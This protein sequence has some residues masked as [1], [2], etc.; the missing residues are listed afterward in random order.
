MS[1]EQALMPED[2]KDIIYRLTY[3]LLGKVAHYIP[4]SVSPNQITIVAFVSAMIACALLYFISSPM[5]YLYWAIFNFI[6]YVLDALDGI[7]ARLTRQ[8]SEYGAFLD[9]VL[10]NIFFLI[11]FTVFT[12]KFDLSHPLYVLALMTRITAAVMVFIV[13]VHTGKLYL[14]KL[15][16]GLELLLMTTVMLLFYFFPYFD[17]SLYTSNAVFLHLIQVLD[18]QQGAF[19]KITLWIYLVGVPISFIF[20]FRFVKQEFASSAH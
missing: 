10:D 16:G 20:L 12:I 9:H 11:M 14:S 18:L 5:A 17:P 6:W 8:T 3:F 13:Q 4:R 1:D 15:S 2:Y 7:H 19:M